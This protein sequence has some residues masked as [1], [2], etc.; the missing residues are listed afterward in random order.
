MSLKYVCTELARVVVI[1]GLNHLLTTRYNQNGFR[2]NSPG[3]QKMKKNLSWKTDESSCKVLM[4]PS[5]SGPD[6]FGLNVVVIN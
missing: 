2:P 6:E 5:V 1:C 4:D 3:P